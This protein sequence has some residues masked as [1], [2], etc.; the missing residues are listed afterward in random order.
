[1]RLSRGILGGFKN[2]LVTVQIAKKAQR[3]DMAFTP[4]YEK[5]ERT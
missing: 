4:L 5:E 3:I 1:M 2:F